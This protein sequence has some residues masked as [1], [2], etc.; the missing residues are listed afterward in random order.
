MSTAE[1]RLWNRLWAELDEL[2]KKL[3]RK[4]DYRTFNEYKE[5]QNERM[6]K[7]EEELEEIKRAAV[8]PDQVSTMIGNKLQ[9]ADARGI[10]QRERLVRYGIALL[11]FISTAL[12]LYDRFG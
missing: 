3:D 1:E 7:L 12:L 4:I 10:T 5:E 8:S 2:A 11:T 6:D 9:D